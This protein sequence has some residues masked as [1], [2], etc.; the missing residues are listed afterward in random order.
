MRSCSRSFWASLPIVVVLPVPLT[1]TTRITVGFSV[2]LER[3]WLAEHRRDLLLERLAEIGQIAAR[4]EPADELGGGAHADVAVDQRLFEPLPVLL[5]AGIEGRRRQ[6]ARERAPALAERVAQASEEADPLLLGLL[7]LGVTEELCPRRPAEVGR[8]WPGQRSPRV[9]CA[10]ATSLR[11]SAGGACGRRDAPGVVT[12]QRVAELARELPEIE[13]TTSW[14]KPSFAI[15]GKKFAGLSTRHEGA[16]WTRC[17]RDERPLL[18]ASNPE[19]YRLTPHFEASPAFLLIWL[20]HI[21]ED[22]VRERLIDAWLIQAPKRVGR[23]VRVRLGSA[24]RLAGMALRRACGVRS[25]RRFS[26]AT[27]PQPSTE[28][29]PLG[30]RR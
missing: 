24:S 8:G 21:D 5:V 7:P 13:E 26:T 28:R 10:R 15:R 6:L 16:M 2:E 25:V 12:W 22:E 23:A 18:V 1:P 20:E 14:G 9:T 17:D 29:P 4:L 11:P 27:R 19:A 3:A 30:R